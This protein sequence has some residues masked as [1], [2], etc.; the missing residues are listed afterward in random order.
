MKRASVRVLR[1]AYFI[2]IVN[3]FSGEYSTQIPP[4]YGCTSPH[5]RRLAD[6]SPNV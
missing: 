4:I 6:L 5:F 3:R 1:L 2:K